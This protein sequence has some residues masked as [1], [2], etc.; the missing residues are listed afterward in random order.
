[1]LAAPTKAALSEI[2]SA[3]FNTFSLYGIVMLAPTAQ[4]LVDYEYSFRTS[5][6][7]YQA[8]YNILQV[9]NALAKNYAFLVI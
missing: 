1:M 5:L 3:I 7:L 6:G 9:Q 2:L 8:V 4:A